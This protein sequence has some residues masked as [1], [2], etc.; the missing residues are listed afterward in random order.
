M[1]RTE[2]KILI[3]GMATVMVPK[4]N[5]IN[6]SFLDSGFRRND[7]LEPLWTLYKAKSTGCVA[8]YFALCLLHFA[9]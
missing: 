7:D 6:S 5:S 4:K 2:L 1:S 8:F 3:D 9:L